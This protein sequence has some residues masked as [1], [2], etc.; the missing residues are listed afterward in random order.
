MMAE[1]LGQLTVRPGTN[2][3]Q[4]SV[5]PSSLPVV[6]L[7]EGCSATATSPVRP[8]TRSH[9]S[10]LV[11]ACWN[12][13]K[14]GPVG[15]EQQPDLAKVGLEVVVALQLEPCPVGQAAFVRVVGADHLSA[16]GTDKT[17]LQG[18]IFHRLGCFS[19]WTGTNRHAAGVVEGISGHGYELQAKA[20]AVAAM[21]SPNPGLLR[22]PDEAA[23][24]E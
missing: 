6:R 4:H 21:S 9:F 12:F 11:P 16:E 10:S 24:A 2:T 13:G 18:C 17:L 15:D 7:V 19:L 20:L 3:L 5:S 22:V 1:V 23:Q 8:P 14:L